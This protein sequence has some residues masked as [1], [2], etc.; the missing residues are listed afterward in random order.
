M[1]FLFGVFKKKIIQQIS[2]Q[3]GLRLLENEV[4]K[5]SASSWKTKKKQA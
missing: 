3:N 2:N 5:P 1:L 4:V